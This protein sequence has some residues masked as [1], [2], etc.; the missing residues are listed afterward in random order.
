MTAD[1]EDVMCLKCLCSHPS[2]CVYSHGCKP[3]A[4]QTWK[5]GCDLWCLF[6]D[7]STAMTA[8]A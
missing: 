3:V 8:Q 6:N 5:L 7:R 1:T 2:S 4:E